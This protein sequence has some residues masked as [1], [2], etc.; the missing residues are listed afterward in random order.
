MPVG[1]RTRG[2]P[3]PAA[4]RPA[5]SIVESLSQGRRWS[6]SV[7]YRRHGR[8]SPGKQRPSGRVRA[9]PSTLSAQNPC[10][11]KRWPSVAVSK[12]RELASE[13]DRAVRVRLKREQLLEL[14]AEFL[15]SGSDARRL[16]ACRP[17]SLAFGGVGAS[18]RWPGRLSPSHHDPVPARWC[19][20]RR[21][22]VS[23]GP[24]DRSS[25]D[26]GWDWPK[27]ER[28]RGGR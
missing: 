12:G 26:L 1:Y 24:A 19:S 2:C 4:S 21:G 14:S 28:G 3:D 5:T 13:G 6:A 10:T 17:R 7:Q 18:A 16:A 15:R 25:R 20:G 8:R 23:G 22:L 27:L 11:V 9:S